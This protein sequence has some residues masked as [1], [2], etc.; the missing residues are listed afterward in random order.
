MKPTIA[1]HHYH[2]TFMG[3][4]TLQLPSFSSVE[5]YNTFCGY[6]YA[7][8]IVLDEWKVQINQEDLTRNGKMI[9]RDV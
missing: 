5:T 6:G 1:C 8:T 2:A 7:H 9:T 3:D 4:S